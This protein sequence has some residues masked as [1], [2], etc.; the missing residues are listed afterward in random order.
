MKWPQPCADRECSHCG[1]FGGLLMPVLV[2]VVGTYFFMYECLA[3]R[4]DFPL[5]TKYSHSPFGRERKRYEQMR[6]AAHVPS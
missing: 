6:S 3:C 5:K 2:N 1:K 4:L